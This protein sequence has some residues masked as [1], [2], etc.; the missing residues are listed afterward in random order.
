MPT[1]TGRGTN[2]WKCTP[3]C[4]AIPQWKVDAIVKIR[5]EFDGSI[6]ALRKALS[7]TYCEGCP[8]LHFS[9]PLTLPS[10]D[11]DDSDLVL[12]R[13]IDLLGHPLVCH[14]DGGCKNILRIIRAASTH[15][16]F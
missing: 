3:E 6:P 15:Y 14:N 2:V 16:P 9:K 5:K 10:D 4:K 12:H 7:S 13:N 11:D 8:N 1:Y